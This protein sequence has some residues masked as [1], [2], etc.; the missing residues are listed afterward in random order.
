MEE[1]QVQTQNQGQNVY[2]IDLLQMV[3][4]VL[5]RWYVIAIAAIIGGLIALTYTIYFITPKYTAS[6][7]MY[8]NNSSSSTSGTGQWLSYSDISTARSLVETYVV[9]LTSRSTLER[10]VQESSVNYSAEELKNMLS[11]SIQDETEII[12]VK[13]T[14]PDPYLA[15][16]IA[17]T[18]AKVL[19]EEINKII[20]SSNAKV[21]DEASIPTTHSYPSHKK[22]III[23]LLV[24]ILV[25][26]ALVLVYEFLTDE[27][28][29]EEWLEK[30]Y[31]GDIPILAIIPD[32]N[33]KSTYSYN[34]YRK[35][36]YYPSDKVNMQGGVK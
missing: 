16:R 26:V 6:I 28:K 36:G 32:L 8:I 4:D 12:S 18:I 10:V 30:N 3:K 33:D 17:N 25:G 31:G 14:H 23:G 13:V 1:N 21:V 9:I 5:K 2:E 24:G 29:S 22:N 19:P 11:V 20:T 7:M 27:I 15:A 35:Y 34:R